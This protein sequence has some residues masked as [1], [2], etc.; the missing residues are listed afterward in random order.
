MLCSLL[1]LL[2]TKIGTLVA[3]YSRRMFMCVLFGTAANPP[4]FQGSP[5]TPARPVT[6]ASL[7]PLK[8]FRA[9]CTHARVQPYRNEYF[10]WNLHETPMVAQ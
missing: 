6:K 3:I 10:F 2:E 4:R 7:R 5:F 8:G 9:R 1:W